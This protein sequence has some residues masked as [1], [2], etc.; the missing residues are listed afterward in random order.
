MH[1]NNRN[2]FP[3]TAV[4]ATAGII[5]GVC[6]AILMA[7]D[8]VGGG[9]SVVPNSASS[10]LAI[11]GSV[12]IASESATPS[13]AQVVAD[14]GSLAASKTLGIHKSTVLSVAAPGKLPGRSSSHSSGRSLVASGSYDNTVKVWGP[15]VNSSRSGIRSEVRSLLHNGRVNDLAF[16]TSGEQQQLVTGSGSGEITLWNPQ[17]GEAITTI[18]DKSGCIVS[19]AASP[20]GARFASGSS[21]GTLKVWPVAEI[22][23]QKSQTNLRGQV[24]APSGPQ[25]SALAFHP[26]NKDRLVSGDHDGVIQVWD[27]QRSQPTLTLTSN[28]D[29]IDTLSI[30]PDG[31][32]VAS[33]SYD[34][35]IRIWNLTTGK[36]VQTLLGHDFVVSDVAF[37]PDGKTLASS[38]FDE[39]IKLWNWVDGTALCTLSGHAGFVHSVAFVDGSSTLVSGGYDGTVRSWNLAETLTANG[40]K[41]CISTAAASQ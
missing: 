32:Y 40:S 6:S 28:A 20:D 30:S 22:A 41:R 21:N 13:E 31:Q 25:I 12:A 9:P 16:V 33:G 39:S 2:L 19:I 38:S 37:S 36:P 7:S 23:K 3:I 14:V 15:S 35:I 5:V 10:D 17:S 26:T 34:N 4:L 18:A 24:L 29:R 27:L 8:Q 1:Q 11:D